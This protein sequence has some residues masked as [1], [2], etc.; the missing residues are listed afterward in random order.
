MERIR[1]PANELS[2]RVAGVITPTYEES[3]FLPSSELGS[4]GST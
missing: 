3:N 1:S 4:V 2:R